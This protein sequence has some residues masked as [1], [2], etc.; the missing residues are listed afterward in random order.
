[1]PWLKNHLEWPQQIQTVVDSTVFGGQQL[2]G[3]TYSSDMLIGFNS[4][5][6][7]LTIGLDMTTG[8]TDFNVSSNNF[9][10]NA[11]S[12]DI[13]A[14]VSGFNLMSLNQ[15]TGDNLGIFSTSQ[16]GL[17]LSSLSIA[18]N[19]VNKVAAFVGGI[20]NRIQSQEDLL[21]AQ[22]TNYN[23]AISRLED[24]DVAQEQ[25]ELV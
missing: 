11:L 16:I 13:F 17:T 25:L 21:N 6:D 24:A 4:N 15:V 12:T 1:M 7:L 14:G 8:N 18:L 20:N 10:I 22:V 3:G 2:I 19:N 5:N 23:A 9:N